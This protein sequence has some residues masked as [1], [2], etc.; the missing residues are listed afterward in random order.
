MFR[1]NTKEAKWFFEPKNY[2]IKED[3]VEIITEPN[4]DFWQR[5]YYGFINDN[6]HVLY[7]TT[8]EKYFSFTVKTDFNVD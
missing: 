2:L 4:T 5:T 3:K 6:A 1:F 8:D 7:V